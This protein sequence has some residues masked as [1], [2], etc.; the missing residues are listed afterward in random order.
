MYGFSWNI[1]HGGHAIIQ[2]NMPLLYLFD[3]LI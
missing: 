1:S 3:S 2:V